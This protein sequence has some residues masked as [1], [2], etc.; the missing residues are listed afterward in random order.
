MQSD[1]LKVISHHLDVSGFFCPV[2]LYETKK[3][4]TKLPNGSVIRVLADDPETLHD[5]PMYI[6]R[7]EHKLLST[8]EDSG[9]FNFIIKVIK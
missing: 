8:T 9:E 2:P 4:L 3:A 5:I 7:T 6:D 1:E